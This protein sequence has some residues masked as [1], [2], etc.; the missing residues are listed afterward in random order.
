MST[1]TN[2]ALTGEEMMP[3][4]KSGGNGNNRSDERLL[5]LHRR[6]LGLYKKVADSV[7]VS[8]SYVSLVANGTRKSDKI[9]AALLRE[10][11]K[12]NS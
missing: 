8:P 4:L 11:R 10:L 6:H 3:N 12:I 7:M 1:I 9:M 2:H 5:E